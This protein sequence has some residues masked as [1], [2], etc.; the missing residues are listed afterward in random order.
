MMLVF[1]RL[2]ITVQAFV[3]RYRLGLSV[4][5]PFG[6]EC[7]TSLAD[8]RSTMPSADFCPPGRSPEVSS[9][10]FRALSPDLRSAC[11][12]DMDF[13]VAWL[14]V[15]RSRLISGSCSSTRAFAPRF[16]RTPIMR[17]H[18]RFANPS[19][20]SGRIGDFHFRATEHARHTGCALSRLRSAS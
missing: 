7:L 17:L 12:M 18:L 19:P 9:A 6:L 16:L 10:A 13:T 8:V 20:P 2:P 4:A 14:L 15:P 11:L 1:L 3:P 5:P